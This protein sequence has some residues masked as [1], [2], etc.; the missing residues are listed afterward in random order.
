MANDV[1]D[2]VDRLFACF[3]CGISPP[4]S[5]LRERKRHKKKITGETP[6]KEEGSK[7]ETPSTSHG[8][9]KKS[10]S[11]AEQTGG[12]N[13]TTI[14]LKSRK[15]ISP[16]VF[17]GSPQGVPAKKPAHILRLLREIRLDLK[18]QND[19]IRSKEVWATFPRQEE[20]MRFCNA[21]AQAYVFSYQDHITGQRRF[22]VSTHEEFWRR[23]RNMDLKLRHHYEVIQEGLPCHLYFDLEFEKKVNTDKNEDE[24]VDILLSVVF[25]VLLEKYS[26]QGNE[27]WVIE[28]DSSTNGKFSRHLTIRIPKIAF[29]DNSHVGAFVSEVCLRISGNRVVEPKMNQ[30]FIK[31]ESGSGD[32]T[33]HLFLDSAVYSRNRCFRL[34]YSSKAG[35]SAYLVPTD[36]FRCRNL[37]EKEVFM[38]SL[39]CK[40]DDDCEKLLVCKLDL[41]F[42]KTL[43]FD[44]EVQERCSSNMVLDAFSTN[45][46]GSCVYGKSPF[47]AID[48]F[49]ESIA[50][51]GNVSGKIRCWYWFSEYG[52]MVYSMSSSRYCERIGREHKSN[53]VMFI[54]DFQRGGYYQKCYDPDCRGYKSPLRPLPWD[55]VPDLTP[56]LNSNQDENFVTQQEVRQKTKCHEKLDDTGATIDSCSKDN[57]WW[58][59]AINYADQIEKMKDTS[60]LCHFEDE[61]SDLDWWMDAEKLMSQI[62]EQ[63]SVGQDSST[64]VV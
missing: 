25:D 17:Y 16:I 44:S 35:K 29:K 3:K 60:A 47:P 11:K 39:I 58:T 51:T 45:F 37:N 26:I 14:K 18:K 49:I 15:K 64:S 28:L 8:C 23:Y 19:L 32:G 62:E 31:K 24:M 46:S 42:K 54:V 27:D 50:S 40:I 33:D 1:K 52:L 22:L 6:C 59:E 41:D 30:L 21:H 56:L 7:E 4:Q 2:D 38:D 12:T 5:A 53:H 57:N 48:S 10:F 63:K 13:S 55:I 34:S 20:A 61:S 9:D 36:R 43:C